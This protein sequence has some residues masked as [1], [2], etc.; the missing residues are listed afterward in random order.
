VNAALYYLDYHDLQAP[1]SVRVGAVNVGQFV[2]IA[3]SRS[4]GVELDVVWQPIQALRLTLDYAYNDT[5]IK[6]S[7]PLIDL[8][9]F[10][11]TG[12]R[13]RRRQQP[14]AAPKTQVG[15]QRQPTRSSW[16]SGTLTLGR[17]LRLPDQGLLQRLQSRLQLRAVL[18]S[19]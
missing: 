6:E 4:E 10:V 11:N 1:V 17:N 18:G 8:N 19:G 15:H 2:N 14:A 12:A 9:D 3:K 13:Q 7:V 16:T 5:K